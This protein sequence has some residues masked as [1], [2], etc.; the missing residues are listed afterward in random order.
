[1]TSMRGSNYLLGF[2]MGLSPLAI[3]TYLPSM[4]QITRDF[5]TSPNLVQLSV[6]IYLLFFAIPQ[7]FFGPLSDS[8]GR[9]KTITYGLILF[10]IGTLLCA[11]AP[12]IEI[13]LAARAMQAT[14]SAAISVTVPALIRDRFS[15]PDYT[16]TMGFIMMVMAVSPMVAPA[17][18]GLIFSLAGWRWIFGVLAI[19]TV[20]IGLFFKFAIQE[21]LKKERREKINWQVLFRNYSTLVK[22]KHCLCLSISASFVF[23]GLMTFISAS[24]FVY[25]DLYQ[26]RPE[27]YGYLFAINVIGLIAIT[28]I[29]NRLVY[30][31][32]N[33]VILK[34]AVI[35]IV[36]SS[37]GLIVISF[38]PEPP[39]ILI[40]IFCAWFIGNLGVSS[41]NVMSILMARFTHISGSTAALIGTFRFGIA[42]IAGLAVSLWHTDNSIPLTAVMAC[43][44]LL[45][46]GFYLLAGKTPIDDTINSELKTTL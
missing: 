33:E 1:M 9:R 43:C 7:L 14:G 16:S 38:F 37:I 46:L 27:N 2:L 32:S 23:A 10:L 3:D 24:P 6:S 31:F 34:F 35:S 42:S 36:L 39:L 5:S 18:G 45:T 8:I 30:K 15:G 4:P 12:T 22:D 40:I 21:T 25:I 20:C 19:F 41:A 28:H 17:L 44:G 11:T 26:I 13:F 29:N